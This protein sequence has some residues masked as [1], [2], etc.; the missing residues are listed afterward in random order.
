[1]ILLLQIF[2]KK[3][4]GKKALKLCDEISLEFLSLARFKMFAVTVV[5]H[6]VMPPLLAQVTT[7]STG[8]HC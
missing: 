8:N 1:M 5:L 2:K 3:N 6:P 4:R 7:V